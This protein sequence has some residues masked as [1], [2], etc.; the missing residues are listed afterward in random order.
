MHTFIQ[1]IITEIRNTY[2]GDYRK[3]CIIFPTR[4]A[5]L[6]F[7]KEFAAAHDQPVWAPGVMGIGDFVAKHIKTGV[8][9]EIPLLL[10]LY[11][12]YKKHWPEQDFGRFYGW[13]QMMLNDFDEIDKQLY[14]PSRLFANISEL[15]KIEAAFLPEAESLHWIQEFVASFNEEKLTYL[16]NEFIKS[17][18]RLYE[19]Y[20]AY[21]KVLTGKNQSYEGK[22]YRDLIEQLK[23]GTFTS[24]WDHFV[25]AGF[26]GFSRA[27]E[28]V[29]SQLNKKF[30]VS[31]YWDGDEYYIN[32]TI[33]EAGYY[34]RK[35]PLINETSTWIENHFG[36]GNKHIEFAGVPLQAGQAK[37][38]G[39]LLSNLISSNSIDINSTAIILADENLLFP[40]L[41]AI[42]HLVQ[43]INVT[44][45]YPLKESQFIVLLDQ[46]RQLQKTKRVSKT[47]QIRYHHKD[48]SALLNHPLL[49]SV[50]S[51]HPFDADD[52]NFQYYELDAINRMYALNG[53][54]ILFDAIPDT[55][56]LFSYLDKT[57][58]LIH[59]NLSEK[60]GNVVY[61]EDAVLSFI[62]NEIRLLAD[63]LSAHS[64]EIPVETGWQMV[65]ECIAG[66][67]VPFTGEPVK[68]LQVMGFLE[69]RALDFKNIII[70][71]CNEG[72]LPASSAGKS[73][74]PYALR[75]G[76][77]LAT[78]EDQD[79]SFSYHFYRLFHTA[80][81]AFLIYNTEVGKTGGGEPSRYLLQLEQE[82]EEYMGARLTISK[83]IISTPI[84]QE[85]VQAISIVKDEKILEQLQRFTGQ[86]DN[87]R[88]LSSSALTT[89]INCKLQFYFRYIAYLKEHDMVG[90][91]IEADIFGN[92]LHRALELLYGSSSPQ[93]DVAAIDRLLAQA[94]E[95][96]DRA[97]R[98]VFKTEAG[99][100][101]GNDILLAEVIRELVK[102]MLQQDKKDA[103]FTI[104]QLEGTYRS[105][106]QVNGLPINLYGKF[107]RVDEQ[108]GTVRIIDYKT[109]KV[110]LKMKEFDSLFTDPKKKTLFQLYFY[111]KIYKDLHPGKAVKAGF[112]VAAS[113]GEGIKWP[114]NGD[115]VSEDELTQFTLYLTQLIASVVDPSKPFNQTD[116][117][118]RC[119]YCEFRT[120]CQR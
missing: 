97:I 33:H 42:P 112:Y 25:F 27:E 41:Y 10:S 35:T 20:E 17:W 60:S 68:G 96:V 82:L 88:S 100:L 47:G 119:E 2:Q 62:A 90:E 50:V 29:I 30:Q 28:E 3:V 81:K 55:E 16:Q 86:N 18:N 118:K 66:L 89:Y 54:V 87:S 69:T 116:D 101:H 40:V 14:E 9:E 37:Y 77:G 12:V 57:L 43:T 1:R 53:A 63:I 75:K 111:S 56:G 4:R 103:P 72:I 61:F 99:D 45:G 105:T 51:K 39:E 34:F 13:G 58:E 67:K 84:I 52:T 15:R 73:F 21:D 76:F 11:E 22:A 26:Y 6:I 70:I 31:L 74:I 7:R 110:E 80:E 65:R 91:S 5:C 59:L 24:N 44:M 109:G 95:A 104:E 120:I 46:L 85:S 49:A 23:K 71:G 83:K 117:L 64:S 19:I 48:I 107:D 102:R 92:I 115:H 94:D 106:I 79:A 93:I 98:E 8:T 113:L 108:N 36:K 114:G 78:Y 32:N 38:A